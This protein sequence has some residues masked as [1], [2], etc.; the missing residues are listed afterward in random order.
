MNY[1]VE[2]I[3][4]SLTAFIIFLGL[5]VG[6]KPDLSPPPNGPSEIVSFSCETSCDLSRP[7]SPN[8]VINGLKGTPESVFE[9]TAYKSGF[10]RNWIKYVR[11]NEKQPKLKTTSVPNEVD[12]APASGIIITLLNDL[13]HR[14]EI[15]GV[16]PGI[17][18]F[19]RLRSP[20]TDIA[21]EQHDCQVAV[22]PVD[23]VEEEEATQ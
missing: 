4:Q 16:E 14:V 18:Y 21:I 17:R 3:L 6:C 19:F 11:L 15:S 5:L 2:K 13:V 12:P 23:W 10:Q 8:L 22:C 20:T 7:R 1:P 9:I